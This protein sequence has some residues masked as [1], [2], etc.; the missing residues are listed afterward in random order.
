M[1]RSAFTVLLLAAA[2]VPLRGQAGAGIN[3]QAIGPLGLPVPGARVT[4]CPYTATGK[5]CSPQAT[6]YQDVDL[7][8]PV[9]QPYSADQYGN[10]SVFVAPGTYLLQV[11]AAPGT[12]Y[13]STV[14]ANASGAGNVGGSGTITYVPQWSTGATTL[15]NSPAY[16]QSNI[17]HLPALEGGLYANEWQSPANTGNN[18]IALSLAQCL[19][20]TYA[21]QVLAPSLYALTEAQPFGQ[22]GNYGGGLKDWL[23]A[24]SAYIGN[25]PTSSQPIAAVED[26]RYGVPQ[27]FFNN[28]P[29][30]PYG[31][32]LAFAS[33][34]Y[35]MNSTRAPAGIAGW[36]PFGLIVQNTAFMGGL[37]ATSPTCDSDACGALKTNFSSLQL[38]STKY[39]STQN[40]GDF[41]Q[42]LR[43]FGNGDDVAHQML[44]SGDGGPST[45]SD[46]GS[47]FERYQGGETTQVYS[48]TIST[49]TLGPD[50]SQNIAVTSP[51]N[52]REAGEDRD[53]IDVTGAYNSSTDYVSSIALVA[54]IITVTLSGG[55]LASYGTT[56]QTTLTAVVNNP[57]STN[58]F[59]QSNTVWHIASSSGFSVGGTACI[60]DNNYECEKITVVS[61]GA[62]TVAT[63]RLPHPVGAWVTIGG[64]TGQG[65]EFVA[66]RC[67]ATNP[68]AACGV[69]P[70]SG[71]TIR[72]VIPIMTSNGSNTLT[73]FSGYNYLPGATNDGY[74]GRAYT[75]MAGSGGTC[76]VTV[77]GGAVTAVSVSGGTGYIS[78]QD[79]P[80]LVLSGS[81]TTAPVIYVS[82]VI[83]GAL[84]SGA[85][86]NPGAGISG[87]PSCIVAT[88]NAYAIYPMAKVRQVYDASAGQVDGT[89]VTDP[90][91]GAFSSGNTI[92]EP[93]WFIQRWNAG[94][95]GYAHDI[96]AKVAEPD[97]GLL[98]YFLG[99]QGS[100]TAASYVQNQTNPL[101]YWGYPAGEPGI[102]GLGQWQ[103][104]FGYRMTGPYST[105][106]YANTPPYGGGPFGYQGPSVLWVGCGGITCSLW[107]SYNFMSAQNGSDSADVMGYDEA[108]QSWFM[109]AGATGWS[110]ANPGTPWSM[111]PA[112]VNETINAATS[113]SG[114]ATGF[115]E[116]WNAYSDTFTGTTSWVADYGLTAFTTGQTDPYGGSTATEFVT[117]GH[118][119]YD[120]VVPGGGTN[121]STS[122]PYAWGIWL[123]GATGTEA[124]GVSIGPSGKTLFL[125]NGWK[126]YCVP[127][128]TPSVTT[129]VSF[130]FYSPT[131]QTFWVYNATTETGASCNSSRVQPG[132][133]QQTTPAATN[134]VLG[135][136]ICTQASGCAPTGT[137]GGDLSG[138]YPNPTVAK[139]NGGAIP[140]SAGLVGTNSS[141]QFISA[142][143]HGAVYGETPSLTSVTTSALYSPR[144]LNV[145]GTLANI[146]A[147]AATFTCSGNPTIT[148]E[149]CG[150]S[151]ACGSP[152]ALASVTLTAANTITAGTVTTPALTSGHY[153]AWNVTAGT[154]TALQ[155]S[156]S[157]SY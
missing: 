29:A 135:S 41:Q 106:L 99:V 2:S 49:I 28:S 85:I 67:T 1:R 145:S 44:I 50:G 56:T 114:F 58:S 64:A 134:Q 55:P 70:S 20:Y 95:N 128:V 118:D 143:N 25:G 76:S 52:A 4:V 125:S 152:A 103:T 107:G 142:A 15:G 13:S 84:A 80:Q 149:D 150:T 19:T 112:G 113:S 57:G 120:D 17:L 133:A 38:W 117:T 48:A 122:S 157:A 82:G 23:G 83:G 110:G 138:S 86:A 121:L 109:T 74:T 54:N 65:F 35:V 24:A 79:P 124:I 97:S 71:S 89:L 102:A 16:V 101:A 87:T 151:A 93:H 73:L 123:K 60:F 141:G 78:A 31:N 115:S 34:A 81:W 126:H 94:F 91:S 32:T 88:Q 96:P 105:D 39:T 12:Y 104:P 47:E 140:V 59:P 36:F 18:G 9:T 42:W 90:P 51:L 108:T 11:E 111:S 129:D 155:I 40:T 131:A 137:A 53:A 69:V 119:Q 62:I 14:T 154:C 8:R 22:T 26:L 100:D 27:W 10:Y 156:G 148:L 147:L 77:S 92:E 153:L 3:G 144:L 46:E 127:I 146:T 43:A 116:N 33:P 66:D 45:A 136:N 5:P 6:I 30:Y 63:D 72:W 130:I 139:V 7:T 37:N 21:C 68:S 75:A 61:T 132:S 98:W